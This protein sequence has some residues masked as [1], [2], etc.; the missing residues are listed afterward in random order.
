ML[1]LLYLSFSN[2]NEIKITIAPISPENSLRAQLKILITL[3]QNY[4]S[5]TTYSF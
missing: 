1:P 3:I 5:D 2:S 4:K